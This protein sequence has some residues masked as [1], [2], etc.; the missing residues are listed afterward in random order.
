[1]LSSLSSS[2]S[3]PSAGNVTTAAAITP[4]P[5][6]TIHQMILDGTNGTDSRDGLAQMLQ[7]PDAQ[8][9]IMTSL[10]HDVSDFYRA[11]RWYNG[12]GIDPSCDLGKGC[13]M[14]SFAS[15]I[16]NRLTGWVGWEREFDE[17]DLEREV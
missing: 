8:G 3:S 17:D 4:C 5:P 13:C 16:A 11:A 10:T 2:S 6:A 9:R 1:M 14:Q 15:D 7:K 12:G